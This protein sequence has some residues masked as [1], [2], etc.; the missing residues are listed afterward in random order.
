MADR[1]FVV[2]VRDKKD[3]PL[4]YFAIDLQSGGYSWLS[5][6]VAMAEK[7]YSVDKIPIQDISKYDFW[8]ICE[9]K[10]VPLSA[11]EHENLK[12]T[13]SRIVELEAELKRLKQ[14]IS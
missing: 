6:N 5:D 11:A 7:F 1:I 13:A 14:S 4:R 12:Q 10:V 9:L 3:S 2:Q 8:Q